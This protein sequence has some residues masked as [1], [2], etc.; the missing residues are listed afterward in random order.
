[1]SKIYD[2]GNYYLAPPAP[3][4]LCQKDFLL[5]LDPRFPCQDIQEEQLKK[6]IAYAQALQ[7]WAKRA[8]LPTLGQPHLLA[9]SILK[10]WQ[11]MEW[12]ISFSDD[13]VL[14]GVAP[15]EGFHRNQTK[16]TISGDAPPAFTNVPTEEV[17][18]EEAVPSRGPL[19]N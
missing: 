1:M 6:T 3:N 13:N 12:Y 17:A 4:C 7:Y 16:L 9:R 5:P 8:Y 2:I 14:D 10:L 11:M 19:K 18:I 15:P